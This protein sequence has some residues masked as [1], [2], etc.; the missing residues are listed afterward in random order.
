MDGFSLLVPSERR[1]SSRIALLLGI[2]LTILCFGI[3]CGDF[4]LF[5]DE[6]QNPCD[7]DPCANKENATAGTCT[8]VGDSDYTCDCES[9]YFWQGDDEECVDPC[10]DDPCA[11]ITNAAEES[12]TGVDADEFTCECDDGYSWD[13]QENECKEV[14]GDVCGDLKT[15]LK[16]CDA[17]DLVCQSGCL[18]AGSACDCDIDL[19]NPPFA[20]GISCQSQCDLG[21]QDC[22]ECGVDCVFD[23]RCP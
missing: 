11:E 18:A 19:Y 5:C 22:W 13:A 8:A 20:C 10:I 2:V 9:G 12:C 14:S 15:C 3:G 16:G 23:T 7:P 4:C 6:E 1:S 21:P 17:V